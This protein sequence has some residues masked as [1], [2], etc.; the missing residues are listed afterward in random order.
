MSWSVVAA[1]SLKSTSASPAE[2][3]TTAEYTPLAPSSAFSTFIWQCPHVIPETRSFN[4]AI[5][6]PASPRGMAP[7]LDAHYNLRHAIACRADHAVAAHPGGPHARPA[8]RNLSLPAA[9]PDPGRTAHRPLPPEQGDRG[10]VPLP[11]SGGRVGRV[12]VRPRPRPQP[13]PSLPAHPS[14]GLHA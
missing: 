14:P 8:A 13:R 5:P 2:R 11:R 10:P 1:S 3:S 9:H 4:V 7:A 6:P 12:G